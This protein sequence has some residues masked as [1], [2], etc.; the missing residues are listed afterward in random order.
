[1]QLILAKYTRFSQNP[2]LRIFEFW[3]W[4]MRVWWSG[5]FTGLSNQ[6]KIELC[7]IIELKIFGKIVINQIKIELYDFLNFDSI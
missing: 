7:S 2:S 6:I 3:E 1:V 5:V 4:R